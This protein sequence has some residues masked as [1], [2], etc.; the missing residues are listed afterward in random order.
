M[1]YLFILIAVLILFILI[2][3]ITLKIMFDKIE[4]NKKM[5]YTLD[6][7]VSEKNSEILK[8]K[9]EIEIEQKHKQILAKKIAD[10]SCMSI[11]DILHEL[12]N[13]NN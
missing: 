8:L 2:L 9:E 4:K 13:S 3:S 5:I 7:K 1:K 10:I 11:N 6:S 12:Q